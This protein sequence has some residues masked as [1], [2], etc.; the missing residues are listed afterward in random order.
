MRAYYEE[1]ERFVEPPTLIDGRTLIKALNLAP[2]PVVGDLL[3]RIREA[4]VGG[5]ISTPDEALTF[6]RSYRTSQN[7]NPTHRF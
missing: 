4:Q 3:E 5:E 7:G 2:G 1:R 6:A